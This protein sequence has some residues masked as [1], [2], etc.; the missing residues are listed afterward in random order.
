MFAFDW[1]DVFASA[2]FLFALAAVLCLWIVTLANYWTAPSV[3]KLSRIGLPLLLLGICFTLFAAVRQSEFAYNQMG[4]YQSRD[5][6]LTQAEAHDRI[7]TSEIIAVQDLSQRPFF[8]T[9]LN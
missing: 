6:K 2:G 1:R 5:W 3:H 8:V 7:F 9:S 4:L